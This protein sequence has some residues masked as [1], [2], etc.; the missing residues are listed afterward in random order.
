ML[1]YDRLYLELTKKMFSDG[2][3][4]SALMQEKYD[5]ITNLMRRGNILIDL[6][7]GPGELLK[8]SCRNGLFE[9]YIG[10][11]NS[12]V[13]IQIARDFSEGL[14]ITFAVAEMAT[15]LKNWKEKAACFTCCD[16]L[17]H[18]P[19]NEITD[20]LG[21]IHDRAEPG[22]Q[23]IIS[24]PNR[25]G[26]LINRLVHFFWKRRMGLTAE[27]ASWTFPDLH[28]SLFGVAKWK[29]LLGNSGFSLQTFRAVRFPVFHQDG[30]A[31]RLPRLG[32]CWIFAAVKK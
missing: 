28:V 22:A 6:G 26:E 5:L 14:P 7:C 12:R 13:G 8:K 10:V 25:H 1:P 18:I 23:L 9:R 27:A 2:K 31:K 15:F 17:E 24:V 29:A 19:E 3:H 16:V 4:P 21:L 20:L 11:D 32:L 30:L